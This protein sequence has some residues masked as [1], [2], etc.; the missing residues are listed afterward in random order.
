MPLN[1]ATVT[2]TIAGTT[3]QVLDLGDTSAVERGYL[4]LALDRG[5]INV[6]IAPGTINGVR[7][8]VAYVRPLAAINRG[9]LANAVVNFRVAFKRGN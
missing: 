9:E 5:M 7:Q 4:Q 8:N 1:P 6:A 2:V 3:Y